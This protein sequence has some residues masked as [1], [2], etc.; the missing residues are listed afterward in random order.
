MADSAG[1]VVREAGPSCPVELQGLGGVPDAG[2]DAVV[3]PND[4]RAREIAQHR[5]S[6]FKEIKLA[7]QQAMKLENMFEQMSEGEVQTLNLIVKADVQGSIEALT[8]SLEKL[9]QETV[10]VE[11]VH[12]MVGI[13]TRL[14]P[15]VI[16]SWHWQKD[17]FTGRH[18][19]GLK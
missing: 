14:W 8:D 3:V 11:V 12:G 9:S 4:R 5:Q 7:R 10:K 15:A 17:L 19:D 13:T 18:C 16:W 6:K 1:R 2:D